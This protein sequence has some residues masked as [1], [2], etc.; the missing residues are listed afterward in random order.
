MH[1]Q[2]PALK[3][4]KKNHRGA[5]FPFPDCVCAEEDHENFVCPSFT[6][7]PVSYQKTWGVGRGGV[8]WEDGGAWERKVGQACTCEDCMCFIVAHV[9]GV[10]VRIMFFFFFL[11]NGG[12]M[13]HRSEVFTVP[14]RHPLSPT[15]LPG[16][17]KISAISG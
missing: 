7:S 10:V 8:I 13:S 9:A 17:E 2:R 12:T 15:N 6:V 14:D 3:S 16:Q 4:R 1:E 11:E 5:A